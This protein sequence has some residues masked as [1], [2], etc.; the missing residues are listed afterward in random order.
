MAGSS[1]IDVAE[2]LE[3]SKGTLRGIRNQYSRR[4]WTLVGIKA[5]LYVLLLS[6]VLCI[7]TQIWV[8]VQDSGDGM[9]FV[10]DIMI[11]LSVSLQYETLWNSSRY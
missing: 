7:C 8:S 11:L 4:E 6:S 3:A 5:I 1:S 9:S 10:G 2:K